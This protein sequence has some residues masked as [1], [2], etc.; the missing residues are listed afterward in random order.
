MSVWKWMIMALMG[1]LLL[2]GC[3]SDEVV[4]DL[5]GDSTG[6][7]TLGQPCSPGSAC[8]DG[9]ECIPIGGTAIC[10]KL[11]T[12]DGECQDVNAFFGGCCQRIGSGY[13]CTPAAAC[14][15][16]SGDGDE[17]TAVDG[18]TTSTECTPDTY[19]CQDLQNI[20]RCNNEKKWVAYKRCSGETR[21]INGDCVNSD[22]GDWCDGSTFCCPDTYRCYDDDIQRCKSDGSDYEYYRT[23]DDD[24]LCIDGMCQDID[25]PVDG[26][27]AAD[28]DAADGDEDE[29]VGVPCTSD[30]GCAGNNEYCFTEE[31]S[32][33]NGECR[34]YCDL[35][36]GNCPRGYSCVGGECERVAG[37]CVSD[38]NCEH[39][40]FCDK[41]PGM[42]DGLCYTRCDV[43]GQSCP[44][45]HYCDQNL[46]S[47]N[48][49]K[50]VYEECYACSSN[51][52]C[53]FGEYCEIPIGQRE[54]CCLEMCGESNPCPGNMECQN[55]GR[56]GIG[57]GLGDCG[58][59]CPA[60][61]VCD[62]LYNACALNC[63]KCGDDECCD[64]ASAPNCY[65]CECQNPLICGWGLRSC[66]AGYSCSAIVYGVIGFCI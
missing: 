25:V 44:T 40:Q 55:D 30:D 38:A 57:D 66:C 61:H 43:M 47:L 58:G 34:I 16:T 4:D 20:V 59:S 1:V 42:D 15:G 65:T 5:D 3:N 2:A 12:N 27:T 8:G 56:C 63:P 50:C 60:G 29:P 33:G 19:D 18:D 32:E 23:C 6:T 35:A 26:D 46:S 7:P 11:C 54:G 62:P 53:H 10:S 64:A 21:C 51:A 9:A 24:Q 14:D 36:G 17:D 45:H 28:G 31:D 39:N 49:G 52:A 13:Y 48:Y 37:Y 22:G 41:R